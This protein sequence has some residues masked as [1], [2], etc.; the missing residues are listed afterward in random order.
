MDLKINDCFGSGNWR[1]RIEKIEG[2]TIYFSL[3]DA[4]FIANPTMQQTER[5]KFEKQIT[6]G[7]MQPIPYF[8][9]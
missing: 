4:R 1:I 8:M 6:D 7:K 9:F 2:N 5:E 3:R